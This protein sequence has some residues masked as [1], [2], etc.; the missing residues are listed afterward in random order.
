MD[1]KKK[2]D[3]KNLYF[4]YVIMRKNSGRAE[5]SLAAFRPQTPQHENTEGVINFRRVWEKHVYENIRLNFTDPN[6]GSREPTRLLLFMRRSGSKKIGHH[7][8]Y[9]EIPL[10]CNVAHEGPLYYTLA[11]DG[12]TIIDSEEKF[13]KFDGKKLKYSQQIG[14]PYPELVIIF[15]FFF[16]SFSC[17][18]FALCEMYSK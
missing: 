9:H 14:I 2:L 10:F 8:V 15:F 7:S 1:L 17:F 11:E 4:F 6:D 3:V 12:T 5:H 16:S 13:Y 18:F